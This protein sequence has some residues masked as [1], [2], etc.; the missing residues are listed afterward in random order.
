MAWG[1]PQT[2]ETSTIPFPIL[3]KVYH[4]H[5]IAF[6][7]QMR[8]M[9]AD[10]VYEIYHTGKIVEN[11]DYEKAKE[12]SFV[13]HDKNGGKYDLGKFSLFE[14]PD[15]EKGTTNKPTNNIDDYIKK[16]GTYR[17]KI[18]SI[19]YK[20][21][22]K[23]FKAVNIKQNFNGD[24]FL[25][26]KDNF[27]LKFTSY[28]NREYARPI[29][30]A[31][32]MGAIVDC[33][34]EDVKVNGFTRKDGTSFPSVSHPGG[35]NVDISNLDNNNFKSADGNILIDGSNYSLKRTSKLAKGLYK[36]GYK[37]IRSSDK[38]IAHCT[39]IKAHKDHLHCEK[40]EP[41]K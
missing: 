20:K 17:G 19:W 10:L 7:E 39:Y 2:E 6:V 34:Y 31:A 15:Y 33:G 36:F 40:F 28:T 14:V 12:V 35:I 5:P 21:K 26:S 32:L 13:Y 38:N 29:C 4:F 27:K 37:G 1:E 16:T 18:K 24:C 22:N 23:V 25:Y 9:S 30:F 3:P 11:G 41:K 8:M